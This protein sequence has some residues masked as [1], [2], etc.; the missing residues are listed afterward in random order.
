[1]KIQSVW[2][3]LFPAADLRAHNKKMQLQRQKSLSGKL[4]RNRDITLTPHVFNY[5]NHHY[6]YLK[7]TK[8]AKVSLK[9]FKIVNS[10]LGTCSFELLRK[11]L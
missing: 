9:I 3:E 4:S 10:E 7:Y 2:I 8:R 6:Q 1:M 5:D 11:L